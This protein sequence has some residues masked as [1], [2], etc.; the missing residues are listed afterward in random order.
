MTTVYKREG[1]LSR[2]E[3]LRRGSVLGAGALLVISG[4]AV[5]S[6]EQAWG[7]ETTALKPETMATLIVMARD[8][9]P[10]D[11]V[12]YKYYAIAVNRTTRRRT[13]TPLSRN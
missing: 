13:R 4:R 6:P 12:P 3:V 9:Y 11:Q 7:L 1:G 2:R 5:I 10:H 8:I